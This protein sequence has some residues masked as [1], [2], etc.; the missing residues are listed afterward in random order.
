MRRHISFFNR[1]TEIPSLWEKHTGKKHTKTTIVV[2]YMATMLTFPIADFHNQDTEGMEVELKRDNQTGKPATTEPDCVSTFVKG[3]NHWIFS[4]ETS[5]QFPA[6]VKTW[7]LPHPR[8]VVV[9]PN[10]H[11]ITITLRYLRFVHCQTFVLA[12]ELQLS[13]RWNINP[14]PPELHVIAPY[15]TLSLSTITYF[16][17][18]LT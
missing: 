10:S 1:V 16:T 3:R 11:Q 18:V 4:G 13:D 17:G 5:Q 15:F 8:R 14:H 9:V 2:S 7:S 6:Q 12:I